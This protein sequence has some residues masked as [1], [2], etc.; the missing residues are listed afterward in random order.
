ML[1]T[2]SQFG[3][4]ILPRALGALVHIAP[5]FWWPHTLFDMVWASYQIRK[6]GGCACAG[7][8][9]NV[10]SRHRFQRKPLVSDPGMH[11]GMCV[12]HVPWCM[13]GSLTSGG[14]GK[15]SRHSRRMRNPQFYITRV[16]P[17]GPDRRKWLISEVRGGIWTPH[18][19]V[20]IKIS[21]D[22]RPLNQLTVKNL[23][24]SLFIKI[25]CF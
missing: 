1:N 12:T 8:A 11:Q 24:F 2:D 21:A 6:I 7:N 23:F 16:A 20:L 22:K 17:W 4:R 19:P 5:W 3:R 13:P 9:G 14:Q 15:R 25:F 10:F 18:S